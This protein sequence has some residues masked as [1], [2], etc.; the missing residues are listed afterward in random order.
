V[1]VRHSFGPA[2]Q[3]KGFLPGLDSLACSRSG[4]FRQAQAGD[5]RA[6]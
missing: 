5:Y 1:R 2:E 4:L 3:G 6:R